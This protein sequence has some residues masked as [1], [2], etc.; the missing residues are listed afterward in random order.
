MDPSISGSVFDFLLPHFLQFYK[1]VNTTYRL[2]TFKIYLVLEHKSVMPSFHIKHITW[3]AVCLLRHVVALT[4]ITS[5][6]RFHLSS[7]LKLISIPGCR[8]STSD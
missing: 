2:I 7:Q 3:S 6:R 4:M 5:T 8:Y 1:E